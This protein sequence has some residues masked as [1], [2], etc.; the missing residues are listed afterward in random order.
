MPEDGKAVV[1]SV[2]L[3]E[4]QHSVHRTCEDRKVLRCVP[5]GP[6]RLTVWDLSL[7]LVTPHLIK[8]T[9]EH[10]KKLRLVWILFGKKEAK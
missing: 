7:Y 2:F 1:P 6:E 4:K 9:L 8:E 3:R 10:D 5:M